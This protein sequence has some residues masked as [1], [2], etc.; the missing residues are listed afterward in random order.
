M[1]SHKE[2]CPVPYTQMIY[3]A[4]LSAVLAVGL[5]ALLGGSRRPTVLI[6]VALAGFVM[7]LCWN[8]VLR[9]TGATGLFSHD[10][11]FKPFPIS[12]QDTGSGV[13][14]IAGASLIVALGPGRNHT[15]AWVARVTVLTAVAALLIDIYTY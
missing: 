5:V 15:P 11:P 2:E 3:G 10:L 14:T 13:C 4:A 12:W 9:T 6:A 8:L 1:R 7:P